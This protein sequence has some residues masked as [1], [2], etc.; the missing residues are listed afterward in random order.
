MTPL[1][2]LGVHPQCL[3]KMNLKQIEAIP[4]SVRY[5][6]TKIVFLSCISIVVSQ[7]RKFWEYFIDIIIGSATLKFF[8]YPR[9]F[10]HALN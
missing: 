6:G 9:Y 1:T 7:I 3:L 5:G 2:P 8:A 4:P 10:G